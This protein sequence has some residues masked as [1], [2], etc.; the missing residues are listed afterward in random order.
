MQPPRTTNLTCFKK[1]GF[2]RP[3]SLP[4][5][6]PHGALQASTNNA[7]RSNASSK[8]IYPHSSVE[9]V[10]FPLALVGCG[11]ARKKSLKHDNRARQASPVFCEHVESWQVIHWERFFAHAL[12]S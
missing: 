10:L 11:Q 8:I 1:A 7:S 5:I 4:A 6:I 2:Y 9:S 12:I 3:F